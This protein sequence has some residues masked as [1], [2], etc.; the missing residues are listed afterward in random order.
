M[1]GEEEGKGER[2]TKYRSQEAKGIKE[3]K[4]R[5]VTEMSGLHRKKP[6]GEGQPKP[7]AEEF[8]AED[9][10]CQPYP[11][12]VGTEGFWE[13]PEARSGLIL[14]RIGTSATC[15]GFQT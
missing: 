7:W 10:V 4:R 15:P 9:G 1:W 13:N 12:M 5:L 2:K 6:L 14:N 8:R 3:S 11:V